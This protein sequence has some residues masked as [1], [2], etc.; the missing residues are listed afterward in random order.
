MIGT[1]YHDIF[2]LQKDH[3]D[4]MRDTYSFSKTQ[5]KMKKQREEFQRKKEEILLELAIKYKKEYFAC[6]WWKFRKK[7]KLYHQWQD[8]LDTVIRCGIAREKIKQR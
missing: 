1:R 4:E 7:S 2:T 5:F 8:T 6:P 3:D